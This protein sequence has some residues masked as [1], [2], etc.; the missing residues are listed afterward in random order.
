M[1]RQ[2]PV[3]ESI[4][5]MEA[6][7]YLFGLALVFGLLF[8]GWPSFITINKNYYGKDEAEDTDTEE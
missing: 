6:F 7:W 5:V 8:H 3:V 4:L 1:T 2:K